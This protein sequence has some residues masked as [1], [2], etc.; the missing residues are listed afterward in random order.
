MALWKQALSIAGMAGDLKAKA[1]L[2]ENL[3]STAQ[4]LGD[5]AEATNYLVQ[6]WDVAHQL[7]DPEL[8]DRVLKKLATS[9]TAAKD[10]PRIISAY[11]ELLAR[12]EAMGDT[13]AQAQD[14][15]VLGRALL[16]TGKPAEAAPL[17][18]RAVKLF[19]SQGKREDA[20]LASY[21][22]GQAMT[23][24]ED[25]MGAVDAYREAA[26]IARETGNTAR[27][28]LAR[29]G[30]GNTRYLLGD[31]DGAAEGLREAL[32]LARRSGARDIE[33]STLMSLGN[34]QFYRKQPK[35]AVGFW[36]QSLKLARALSD[37][38]MEGESLGNLALAYTQLRD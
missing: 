30:V 6:A 37:R 13:S 27:E 1:L 25:Y 15:A 2:L 35:E 17:L 21:F 14:T 18:R 26:L 4:L 23:I 8:D 20:S 5:P 33:A 24:L 11:A 12:A 16:D 34:V 29:R 7:K 38:E 36:E 31:F 19:S 9:A 10:R 3:G 22:V 28:A 32:S